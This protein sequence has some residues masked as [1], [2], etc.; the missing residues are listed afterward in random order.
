MPSSLN[1]DLKDAVP[2]GDAIPIRTQAARFRPRPRDLARCLVS[3]ATLELRLSPKPGLV[4][5]RDNGSHPDLTLESM[6]RSVSLLPAYY[7]ELLEVRRRGRCFRSMVEAGCRAEERMRRQV[8]SNAHRGYIFLSGLLLL[9]SCEQ[10]ES[11]GD[12]RLSVAR[13]AEEF[14]HSYPEPVREGCTHGAAVRAAHHLGGIRAEALAGLPSVFEVGLPAFTAQIETHGDLILSSRYLMAR[15][16]QCV[17]DTT[18]VHR[19]GPAGLAR[20]RQ[21]GRLLQRVLEEN[22]DHAALL[23]RWNDEYRALGLTMGGVADCLGLTYALYLSRPEAETVDSGRW[24]EILV[25]ESRRTLQAR[26]E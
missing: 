13:L 25:Q 26:P 20:I 9:A 11:I 15:L 3:G 16:M 4:D 14:F 2:G 19:C 17:E 22:G 18:A 5:L 23:Q 21:D 6:S 10:G 24:E 12:L 1:H 8:G 7:G